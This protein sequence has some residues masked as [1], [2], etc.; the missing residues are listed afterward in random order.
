[1]SYKKE[2]I[3]ICIRLALYHYFFSKTIKG[4]EN[5][6]RKHKN[7]EKWEIEGVLKHFKKEVYPVDK[8]IIKW[9]LSIGRDININFYSNLKKWNKIKK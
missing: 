1:M 9:M 7:L 8:K 2:R 6:M 4:F 3:E 5:F